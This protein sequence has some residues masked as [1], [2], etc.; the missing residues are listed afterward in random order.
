MNRISLYMYRA[1]ILA[2]LF[3]SVASNSQAQLQKTVALLKGDLQT[4][5]GTK[6]GNANISI[7]KSTEK[8]LSTRSN[9]DGSFTA[10]LQP[11]T[12]YR[13]AVNHPLYFYHE[14][15]I[16][17]PALDKYAEI[18]Y[19]GSVRP[20]RDGQVFEVSTQIF[21]YGSSTLNPAV[22][23]Q[24]EEIV[25]AMKHNQRLTLS[26]IVYPD[27]SI[28]NP[29]KDVAQDRLCAA[30]ASAFMSYFLAKNIPQKS[31]TVTRSQLASSAEGRFPVE[32]TEVKK[33][34]SK[35][36]TV[37]VPQFAEIV[38]HVMS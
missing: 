1:L 4:A 38:A 23:G 32:I 6:L 15:T 26:I 21:A 22:A 5:D 9:E 28:K 31:V 18:P 3:L 34:K 13:I 12:T 17:V 2:T 27:Q 11:N 19:H 8:I 10:V 24:L 14:D 25:T 16:V 37:L 29:K 33:K 20:L 30:R 36:M 7:F 35:K